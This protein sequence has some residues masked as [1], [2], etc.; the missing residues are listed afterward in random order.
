M[1]VFL[2]WS[3]DASKAAALVLHGWLPSI[4]HTL[5]P[6]MSAESIEKG[7][8]WSVDIAKQL[9]ETHY[10]VIC[11][12]PENVS[13]PWILF[14]A[15]ALS[16][17]M[18]R[19][20]VSPLLFGL[21]PSDLSGSPLLQ[22]QS[23][24]FKKEEVLKLVVSLNTAAPEEE[25]LP[26]EI[27]KKSFERGW[28]ELEQEIGKLTFAN[29]AA[30]SANAPKAQ[31]T[32]QSKIE[33]VLD[34]LLSM[35][36]SQI[37]MLRSPEDIL[38]VGYLRHALSEIESLSRRRAISPTHPVWREIRHGIERIRELVTPEAHGGSPQDAAEKEALV[39]RALEE[40]D[41]HVSYVRRRL[42]DSPHGYRETR[43]VEEKTIVVA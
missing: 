39:V 3:G 4:I 43:P 34:E 11:V 19:S 12:T 33:D 38:P 22:F 20:R 29:P 2:S 21:G 8:R 15:G 14:E 37:K 10:G 35:A 7:E 26:A 17:S 18:E 16:K 23:T 36:R 5:K 28:S 40:L 27:L 13:A 25:K 42:A 9:E 32:E 30:G 6:Y 31:S 1:K 41:T 24:V